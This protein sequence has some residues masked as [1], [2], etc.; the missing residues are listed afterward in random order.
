MPGPGRFE[1]HGYSWWNYHQELEAE[2]EIPLWTVESRCLSEHSEMRPQN[3]ISSIFKEGGQEHE[4]SREEYVIPIPQ[5]REH[6]TEAPNHRLIIKHILKT[7][8]HN[9]HF[10]LI[11]S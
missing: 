9:A 3:G 2:K 6:T 11:K 7:N 10:R 5:P 1:R 4:C 8:N